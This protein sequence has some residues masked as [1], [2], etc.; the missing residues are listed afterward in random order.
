M[1]TTTTLVKGSLLVALLLVGVILIPVARKTK[2]GHLPPGP[3]G[4]PLVGNVTDLPQG[5]VR[6][7]EHWLKHK[8]LYG[9]ISSVTALGT[10]IILVHS[11]EIASEL[12]EKRSAKYSSR[13]RLVFGGEMVGWGNLTGLLKYDRHFRAQRKAVHSIMGT[14]SLSSTYLPLQEAEVHRFLLRVLEKPED[15]VQH[16]RTEAGAIILKMVY[17]YS[18]GP[19]TSDPLVKLADTA[20]EQ[21]SIATMP[22]LWLVDVIPILRHL[23]E[24]MPGTNF[25]RTAREYRAKM[26]EM[27]EAP[28]EFAKNRM[29]RGNFEQSYV[30]DFYRSKGG[31]L[32]PKDEYDLKWTAL[33]VYGGGAD[34]TVSTISS[35]WLAMTLYPD[36]QRKAQEEID[37]V[38]GT[39]RLPSYSDRDNLPYINAIVDEAWRF[40]P[41]IPM[42]VAHAC[43]EDDV[44][45]FDGKAYFIPKNSVILAN[46]WWF[47]HDPKHYPDPMRFDPERYIAPNKAPDPR[48][49][50]FGYGRRVCPGRHFAEFTV[51]ITIAQTLA[52]FDIGK[53][54][55][56][57]GRE[58]QNKALFTSG[59]TT[60]PLE[61]KAT[62]KPRSSRHE[63]LIREVET[64]H[65]WEKSDAEE[66]ESIMARYSS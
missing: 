35:F 53:G 52:V 34:T 7:W 4:W 23:P 62:I 9:P 55:D 31:T 41:V 47:T 50:V 18:T 39:G 58:I 36:V 21:F 49:Y 33:S 32:S 42:G 2:R 54:R 17:G 40:H 5:G 14:P 59:I 65:P 60:H 61:F 15:L 48:D 64:L 63:A 30:S 57:D 11:H 13:T 43:S 51:W 19:T 24:W 8:D 20:V 28:W 66:V 56:M 10:T 25:K 16:I 44:V 26:I 22:G 12:F 37:R 27:L 1:E 29:A 45:E 3:R 6:E 46:L 38:I